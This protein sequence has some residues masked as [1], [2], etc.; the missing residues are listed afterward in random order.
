MLCNHN[1]AHGNFL[2]GVRFNE[3]SGN[4]SLERLFF[5]VLW[6]YGYHIETNTVKMVWTWLP[7]VQIKQVCVGH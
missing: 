1:A 7:W 5:G 4:F 6:K 3:I 2:R